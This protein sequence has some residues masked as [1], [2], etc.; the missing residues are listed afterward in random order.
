MDETKQRS[1][2][3]FVSSFV[4]YNTPI[5][6][7]AVAAS[8]AVKRFFFVSQHRSVGMQRE[9]STR[10][11]GQG[12]FISGLYTQNF[13]WLNQLETMWIENICRKT[14]LSN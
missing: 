11:I 12:Q 13:G 7:F 4:F 5:W 8:N 1:R 3:D 9:E 10:K 6:Y 2:S 14:L